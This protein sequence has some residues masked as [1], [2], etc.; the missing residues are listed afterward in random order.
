MTDKEPEKREQ[1]EIERLRKL[2]GDAGEP[3]LEEEPQVQAPEEGGEDSFSE[4]VREIEEKAARLRDTSKMPEPPDW[5]FTRP[6][7][8]GNPKPDSGDHYLGFGVGLS[9]AYTM[10]GSCVFGWG[11]GKLI[12]MQTGGFAGQAIGTLVGAV[13]GLAGAIFTITKS[14]RKK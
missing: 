3:D 14:Q 4:R 2:L 9:V 1:E 7:I 10:V 8:P 5:E 12:D 13:V 6:E 11:A